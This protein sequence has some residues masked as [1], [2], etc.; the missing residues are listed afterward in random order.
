MRRRLLN[1]FPDM[2]EVV[3]NH[4]EK[5]ERLTDAAPISRDTGYHLALHTRCSLFELTLEVAPQGPIPASSLPTNQHRVEALHES[6]QH[7]IL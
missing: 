1:P 3:P 7:V 4:S 5:S 2:S 6:L